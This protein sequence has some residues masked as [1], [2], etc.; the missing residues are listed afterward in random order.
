MNC[1]RILLDKVVSIVH[2]RAVQFPSLQT[3]RALDAAARLGSY[4]HAAR[5]LG[6]THG[7]VSHRLR[8]LE[9]ELGYVLFVRDGNGM[10]PTAEAFRLLVPI[11]QALALLGS[12]FP[13]KITSVY[14]L[15]VG[16]LP[17]FASRWL[18]PRVGAFRLANPD[19]DLRL[20]ARLEIALLGP[21]G[22]DCAIRY[23][24]AG[25]PGVRAERLAGENLF[26]VCAPHYRERLAL[27][28]PSRLAKA[29]LLRHDRQLW[30]PWL[31]KAGLE[32]PEPTNGAIF[33]DTGLLLDAA[34]AGDGVALAR[35]RLV[36]GDLA[37]GRLIKLFPIEVADRYDY[38]FVRPISMERTAAYAVERF[39]AWLT[40]QF[41]G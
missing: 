32:W 10:R 26:A 5:E 25:W 14:V 39:S 28:E 37:S 16:L 35:A 1:Q 34:I 17:S 36:E 31:R 21:G 7:A 15:R 11:R 2:I 41:R 19:I 23:G 33:S 30:M 24:S 38:Y 13:P 20:D 4:T 22:V 3:L 9:A 27:D 8:A 18:M 12:A 29:T 40:D 6:L